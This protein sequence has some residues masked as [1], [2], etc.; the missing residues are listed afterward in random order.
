[1]G[2]HI[3]DFLLYR[4]R[5]ILGYALIGIVITGLLV[6]A[7]LLIPGGLS[8]GEM[9]SVVRSSALSFDT[10]EPSMIINLPYQIL[11]RLSID[12]LGVTHLSIKLPSL[13]LGALSILGMIILLRAW[14]RR[15]V[16]II[17]TILVITTGQF[18]YVAQSGT[19]SI[20]YIFWS[21]WLL[22]SALMVSRH[23]RP[24]L[25][26]KI[27]VFTT[28]ALSLYTPLS[29]YI[30]LALFSA[31]MLHPHLRYIIRRLSK[32]KLAIALLIALALVAPLNYAII[33]NP[34]IGLSL[35]GIPA[36]WPNLWEN[37]S[38]LLSQ[39]F[40][41]ISPATNMPLLLPVY[42]LGSLILIALGIYHLATTKYTA[43]SYI[44]SAWTILLIPILIINPRYTSVTF[45]PVL[46]LMA[47]GIY[48]LLRNWYQLF[49]RNP[50]ARVAGLVPLAILIG[51]LVFSGIDRYVYG[52][53]YNPGLANNFS[54]DLRLVNRQIKSQPG[55]VALIVSERESAFYTV[56]AAHH[57]NVAVNPIN[58]VDIKTTI[59][60]RDAWRA[61]KP[62]LDPSLI[63]TDAKSHDADRLYIYKSE[64]K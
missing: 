2:K 20:V 13:I 7:G 42:G 58:R 52:Y 39:Y 26:W 4:W 50:Y 12:L 31:A 51:G 11:Q 30:L 62:A 22:A 57:T 35:L 19:P 28:A 27:A 14:F 45:V 23:A 9:Q 47:M 49:P 1:M 63:I 41:F 32:G 5:Y 46:L 53:L 44:I 36:E 64:Q 8:N 24:R 18:L 6:V 40:D 61:N 43:R 59:I 3:T 15:N 10:F 21:V 55:K 17:A 16:A 34:S 25:F 60:T 38:Q 54:K 33:Q 48:T 56:V 37:A 29:I